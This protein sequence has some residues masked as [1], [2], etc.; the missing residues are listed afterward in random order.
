MWGLTRD[1]VGGAGRLCGGRL[2][3]EEEGGVRALEKRLGGVVVGGC[4]GWWACWLLLLWW[5]SLVLAHKTFGLHVDTYTHRPP[6]THKHTQRS[7]LLII[8]LSLPPSHAP[9]CGSHARTHAEREK[10][11]LV[12]DDGSLPPSPTHMHPR[13]AALVEAPALVRQ[14][15]VVV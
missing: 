14:L 15:A 6:Q 7:W 10:K 13:V 5:W 1:R 4:R 2:R 9:P 3:R 11:N 12:D 8:A